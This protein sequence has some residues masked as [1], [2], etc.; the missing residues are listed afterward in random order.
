MEVDQLIQTLE[1]PDIQVTE[2]IEDEMGLLDI[3]QTDRIQTE[4]PALPELNK[5]STLS[6]NSENPQLPTPS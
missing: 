5:T 2:V 4:V 1:I 3:S 6:Q